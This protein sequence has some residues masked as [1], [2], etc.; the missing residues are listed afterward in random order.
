MEQIGNISLALVALAIYSFSAWKLI[1]TYVKKGL[2]NIEGSYLILAGVSMAAYNHF[3]ENVFAEVT[4]T[5][6]WIARFGSSFLLLIILMIIYLKAKAAVQKENE[7]TGI[8][9]V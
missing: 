3:F 7:K 4:G 8:R 9:S 1:L 6:D 5:M 2:K